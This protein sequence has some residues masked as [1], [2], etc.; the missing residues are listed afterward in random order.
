MTS[1]NYNEI[2]SIFYAKVEA[3]D[4]LSLTIDEANEFLCS[5]IRSVISKPYVRRLFTSISLDD[6]I[7]SLSY[8][9]KYS[10]D[11]ETDRYF[12]TEVIGIG[13]IIQWLEPKINSTINIAQMFGSKEEK[14]Y[15]QAAHLAELRAL[16]DDLKRDQ[17]GMIRDRGYAWNTYLDG[18]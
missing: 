15:S 7:Q 18:E 6:E 13:M 3:Y 9:L 17:R 14:Y 11:E 8:E 16:R 1:L 12:V 10:I 4:F 5:W 2:F